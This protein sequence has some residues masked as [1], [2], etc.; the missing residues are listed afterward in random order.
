VGCFPA[1]KVEN[2]SKA[3]AQIERRK[4][5]TY[6]WWCDGRKKIK[7][8]YIPTLEETADERI[9]VMMVQ[10]FTSGELIANIGGKEY[11]GWWE[12]K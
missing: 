6:R 10:G 3:Q 11:T 1:K 5:I 9:A 8:E 12:V 2:V 4:T 7:P